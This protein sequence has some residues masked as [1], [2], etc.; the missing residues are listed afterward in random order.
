VG[1]IAL[2]VVLMV[3]AV[4]LARSYRNLEGTELGFDERHVLSARITLGNGDYTTRASAAQFFQRLIDDLRRLPGVEAV[5][6]AQGIPFSGWNV[7]ASVA[8]EDAQSPKAGEEFI[9]HYQYVTPDYFKAIGV[10]LVR[11]RWLTDA[12]RDSLHP[13]VLV[14]EQMVA[15]GFGGRDP[16]GKRLHIGGDQEPIATV[17]GV[18]KDFRH[19]RLP[20]R[21]GP[22]IYYPYATYPGR[23]Q[24]IVI[25]TS[26]D[27]PHYLIPQLRGTVRAIDPRVALYQVQTLRENV[28]RSL[29]RQRLQGS[30]VV[31]FAFLAFGLA[32]VGLYGVISYVVAQ[33]TREL[34]VRIA[35]GASRGHV[36]RLVGVQSGRLVISG[37]ALGLLGAYFGVGVLE[38]L[39]YGIHAKDLATFALVPLAL[40]AVALIAAVIPATRATRVDPIVAMRAE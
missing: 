7:Q 40:A 10:P 16:I 25:R 12:D 5:G 34:G 1:E 38:S 30:V 4:L 32:C 39:L 26:R 27:D 29:W 11:G 3:G 35:L 20:Q 22:A 33:R 9:S 2:S 24:T 23:Q 31:I 28:E 36:L 13:A 21:M 6:S 37:I 17:V 19:Y 18:V 8:F 15:K 14:N